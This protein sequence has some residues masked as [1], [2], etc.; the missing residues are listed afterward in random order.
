M[1]TE[2]LKSYLN[3]VY[4]LHSR[5]R[6]EQ[7]KLA[8]IRSAVEYRSPAFDGS[9]GHGGSDK[10]GVAVANIMKREQRVSD[11]SA[12]YTEKYKE[13]ERV[14]GSL[15]DDT[16]EEVLELRYLRFLKWE[17]IAKQMNYSERQTLRLH[18]VALKKMQKMSPDVIECHP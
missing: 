11:L 10:V 5:L 12:A 13:V 3:Q 1:T 4:R 6:R 15:G 17:D 9:G 14:I 2:E 16:L 18:G 7:D 8:D